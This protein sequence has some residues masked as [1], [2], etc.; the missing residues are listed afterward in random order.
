[1][2]I[3]TPDFSAGDRCRLE[4]NLNLPLLEGEYELGV[5]IAASDFSHFYDCLER[6]FGFS[7]TGSDGAQGLV[8]LEANVAINKVTPGG[9]PYG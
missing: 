4:Y 2:K 7:I 6:A 8:D 5:D 9:I 3:R 1:M